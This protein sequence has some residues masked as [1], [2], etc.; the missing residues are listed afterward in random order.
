MPR[1]GPVGYVLCALGLLGWPAPS[2]AQTVVTGAGAS[3]PGPTYELWLQAY[4]K[5][6][7]DVQIG[8][9]AI[10]SGG[11]IRQ[12][13]EGAIDFGATDGPMSD[14]QLQSYKESHGYRLLHFATV[15]GAD[16]PV[17]NLPGAPELNF[18]GEIL[19]GIYLGRITKWDDPMLREANPKANLPSATIVVA[20]RSEGSGTTYIWSDYLCKV[21]EAWKNKVGTGFSINWPVGLS[22]RGNDGVSDL[23]AKTP[24]SLG[25]V[26]LTYALQKH[27][28][29]GRVRNSAGNFVKADVGSIAAGAAEAS[30]HIAE[31]FRISITNASGKDTYPISSFSWLLV[32]SR[33]QDP[34]K[35]KAIVDFLRWALTDGQNLTQQLA[36]A[37]LPTGVASRELLAAVS[38]I[39]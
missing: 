30:Q 37:R 12:I 8:Y 5:V 6:H 15:L 20:H 31:D 33:I 14:R 13:L 11:G 18:T 7:P 19:S 32:P 22:A 2:V 9:Q 27:L 36:Y 17:Y 34:N 4:K 10:G 29:C 35:R 39:Q 25:Y 24:Y 26:E 23:I 3:F 16:V 38:Q 1:L 28:T 21:S